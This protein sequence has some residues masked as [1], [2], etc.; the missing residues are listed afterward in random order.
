MALAEQLL[1]VSVMLASTVVN[2][3]THLPPQMVPQVAF[4]QQEGFAQ[5][6]LLHQRL[7]KWAFT[8]NPQE[9]NL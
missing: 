7:V 6:D 4:V 5:R 9:P 3:H 2:R 1:L 8:A